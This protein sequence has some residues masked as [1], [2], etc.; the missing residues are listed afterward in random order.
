MT[1]REVVKI[2]LDG[3]RPPYVPWH[4]DFTVE[5]GARLSECL[6]T[7]DLD[8]AVGNHFL[9][10]GDPI[11]FVEPLGEGRFRDPFGVVWNRNVDK[12]IG[13][14]DGVVLAEPTLARYRFPDPTASY[15]FHGVAE[16]IATRGDRFRVYCIGFSLFER[17]WTLRGIENLLVDFVENPG[18]VDD[19]F[20]AI[21]DWNI[22][23]ARK[24]LEYDIDAIYF[25]DDWGQQTGLIMGPRHWRRFIRP[26]LARMYDVAKSAGKYQCIH[27]CG[28]VRPVLPDLIELGVDCI[29]PFQPEAMPVRELLGTYRGRVTFYGGLSTQR[30]L[31]YGDVD[32]VRRKSRE[33]LELGA[34][35]GLVFAPSHAVVR[36]TPTGNML[37]FLD[38]LRSQPAAAGVVGQGLP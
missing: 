23:L 37:A 30:T 2:V 12:D 8:E 14:V 31:P 25:G 15:Y 32:E 19:L 4:C 18:F 3:G 24:A 21:C 33:L 34:G 16:K 5:A 29:N 22:E 17:A 36:D 10:L 28:D 9:E 35:G 13:V 11:G 1:R 20:D 27:S 7:T 26:R 6:G 38:E